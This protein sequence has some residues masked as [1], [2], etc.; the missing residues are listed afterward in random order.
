MKRYTDVEGWDNHCLQIGEEWL[1]ICR[2][3][4]ESI[5][6]WL[7]K[8]KR[9]LYFQRRF[10]K[11]DW[12][13]NQRNEA[14]LSY[15]QIKRT[16]TLLEY[17]EFFSSDVSVRDRKK[18]L[19]RIVFPLHSSSQKKLLSSMGKYQIEFGTM[20]FWRESLLL[21]FDIIS[22]RKLIRRFSNDWTMNISHRC[23]AST[24]ELA[25]RK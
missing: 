3:S 7:F 14:S 15:E 4:D 21:R 5:H 20:W 13:N 16:E 8:V 24:M 19:E 1:I 22:E 11:N 2:S 10:E 12:R 17:P 6:R 25:R 9:S 18:D 23:K